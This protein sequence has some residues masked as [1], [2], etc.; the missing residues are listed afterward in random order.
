MAAAALIAMIDGVHLHNTT[1][2]PAARD[3]LVAWT[4]RRLLT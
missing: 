1:R 2:D 3:R 4:V